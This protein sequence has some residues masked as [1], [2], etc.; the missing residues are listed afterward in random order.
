MIRTEF[1]KLLRNE[2]DLSGIEK[3]QNEH[4]QEMLYHKV[5]CFDYLRQTLMCSMD[6]TLESAAQD[7][8]TG[9]SKGYING[10]DI[11]HTCT[12]KVSP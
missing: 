10:W 11:Q 8:E 6:M 7:S 1:W 5:H 4:D 2:S 3:S 12:D 9:E